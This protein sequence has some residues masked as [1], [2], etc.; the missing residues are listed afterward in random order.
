MT[1]GVQVVAGQGPY[2]LRHWLSLSVRK[3][4]GFAARFFRISLGQHAYSLAGSLGCIPRD[5]AILDP[6]LR[7]VSGALVRFFE[8]RRASLFDDNHIP[9]PVSQSTPESCKARC[10][11]NSEAGLTATPRGRVHKRNWSRGLRHRT[12]APADGAAPETGS[13]RR[14]PARETFITHSPAPSGSPRTATPGRPQ[15]VPAGGAGG[16]D[17]VRKFLTHGRRRGGER[18]GSAAGRGA[19]RRLGARA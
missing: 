1:T 2:F 19:R 6:P 10:G 8:H 11:A 4:Q 7:A 13:D 12:R 5:C 18:S 14:E 17:V 16:L 3:A 15:V 9:G